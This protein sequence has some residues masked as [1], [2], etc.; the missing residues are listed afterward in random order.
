MDWMDEHVSAFEK[1]LFVCEYAHAMGNA[2][3]NLKEYWESIEGSKATIGGAIWDW[4][5][6]AIYEPYEMKKGIYRL[7]T[8]YDFPGRTRVTSVQTVS[9]RP[10]GKNHRS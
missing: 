5:D 6:Q 3:G 8:G 9:S 1:P 7:H 2:I 10:H 4:I